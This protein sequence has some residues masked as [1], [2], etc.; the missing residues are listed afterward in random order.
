MNE[1]T[2]IIDP[3]N[4]DPKRMTRAEATATIS[5][6]REAIVDL[7]RAALS[8]AALERMAEAVLRETEP[9]VFD[10]EVCSAREE[11]SRIQDIKA[12]LRR[13]AEGE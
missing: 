4:D 7:R 3:M 11:R 8:D 10:R 1:P 9:H 13:A 2:A 6:L 12:A 5:K